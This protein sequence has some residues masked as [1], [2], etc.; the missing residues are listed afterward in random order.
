MTRMVPFVYS[1]EVSYMIEM[2]D[3][4]MSFFFD[5]ALLNGDGS[6]IATPYAEADL[7]QLQFEQLGDVM[8]ITHVDYPQYKLSRTTATTFSLDK[9]VFERGPFLLRNDLLNDDDNHDL[10]RHGNGWRYR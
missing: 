2:G 3:Q 9:I 5:G 10:Y 4:Y 8:W 7:P 6:P 1:A